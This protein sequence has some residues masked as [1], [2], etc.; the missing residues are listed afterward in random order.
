MGCDDGEEILEWCFKL[1]LMYISSFFHLIT[2]L[3]MKTLHAYICVTY[4][5]TFRASLHGILILAMARRRLSSSSA[6]FLMCTLGEFDQGALKGSMHA[7][8]SWFCT[9]THV[10]MMC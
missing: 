1:S 10:V 5:T 3:S 7:T 2:L 4:T 9:R 6:K 8:S